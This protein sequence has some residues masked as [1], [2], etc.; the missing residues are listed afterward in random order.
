MRIIGGEHRGRR[1]KAPKGWDTRPTPDRVR[2]ALFS[3]LGA[4]I[5][6]A[7][8]LELFGGT[9]SLG[10][11]SLSRGAAQAEFC[12][13]NR[14][15]L[16]C[17]TENI[18]TL[19]VGDRTRVHRISAL[20][21]PRRAGSGQPFDFVFCDPPHRLLAD[22]RTR[23]EI[24]NLLASI[25]LTGNGEAILEHRAGAL[26]DFSPPGMIRRDLRTWGST[27]MAFFAPGIHADSA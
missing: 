19:S 21:F 5:V 23:R 9:G 27:G 17:L 26:A 14:A 18:A 15:A 20:D 24:E 13:I 11:E 1:L 12:E 6:G 22:A 25:P 8:V 7:R 2:E 10:L 16:A 3:I 4:D